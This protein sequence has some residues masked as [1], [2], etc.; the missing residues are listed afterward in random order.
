MNT[1][2]FSDRS[3]SFID[4]DEPHNQQLWSIF[5]STSEMKTELIHKD[6][7]ISAARQWLLNIKEQSSLEN[8]LLEKCSKNVNNM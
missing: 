3:K 2:P 6:L 8:I 5:G 7:F 1:H 4:I